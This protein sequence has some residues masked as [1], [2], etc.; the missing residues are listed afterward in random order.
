VIGA[1]GGRP[2]VLEGT[3]AAPEEALRDSGLDPIARRMQVVALR[4]ALAQA[5][6]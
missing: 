6:A 5:S 4:R 3:D 2:V 1:V